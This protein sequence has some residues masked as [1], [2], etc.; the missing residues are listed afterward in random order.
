[1]RSVRPEGPGQ[2]ASGRWPG[3][4]HFNGSGGLLVPGRCPGLVRN[5]DID[6]G[7]MKNLYKPLLA[8]LCLIALAAP[9]AAQVRPKA[10]APENLHSLPIPDQERVIALEYEEQSGGQRI[11][12]DQMRFYLDQVNRSNWGFSRIKTDIAQSLGGVEG[13]DPG[14]SMRCESTDNRRRTC[15]TPWRGRSRLVSQLSGS[16]CIENRSWTAGYGEVTVW[17]GC[18]AQFAEAWSDG[19]GD[20]GFD[21][22]LGP[23]DPLRERQQPHA[24]LPDAMAGALA[25]QPA[26]VGHPVHRW[27]H[28]RFARRRS[29]GLGWLPCGVPAA[30][31]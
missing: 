16:S 31:E 19:G 30:L 28:L 5:I 14:A 20:G 18:R 24:H 11:P 21:P 29:G 17:N 15:T 10:Y 22:R 7:T 12:D 8:A 4:R 26:D 13:S 1:M 27:P 6:G 3:T 2:V 25:G 9:A 23:A